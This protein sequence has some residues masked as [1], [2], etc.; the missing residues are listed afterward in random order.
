[1][2]TS[3]VSKEMMYVMQH[4]IRKGPLGP[5]SVGASIRTFMALVDRGLAKEVGPRQFEATE[6]GKSFMSEKV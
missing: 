4:L 1:M 6:D 3:R 2:N 5:S